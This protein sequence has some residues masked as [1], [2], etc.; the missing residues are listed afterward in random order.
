MQSCLFLLIYVAATF[1]L[2]SCHQTNSRYDVLVY[3]ST[4]SGIQAAISASLEGASVALI[5]QTARIGGLVASGLGH[6][7]KGTTAAIGGAAMKFFHDVCSGSASP[8]CWDFPPSRALAVFQRMLA[9]APNV[10]LIS[11]Y[12]IATATVVGTRLTSV[13]LNAAARDSTHPTSLPS[14]TLSASYFIDSS[15]EGDL[16]AAAGIQI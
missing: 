9:E 5:S 11:Q 10:T 14:I 1:V 8:P 7:D 12:T 16:I 4:P 15:Y 3:G 2:S 13:T 6:T